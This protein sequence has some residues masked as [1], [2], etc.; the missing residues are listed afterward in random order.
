MSRVSVE[1]LVHFLCGAC[2]KWWS[3]AD[4]PLPNGY[5]CPWCGKFQP[6]SNQ[7]EIT[8]TASTSIWSPPAKN[9]SK[10]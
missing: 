3:I 2:Q 6:Y 9:E 8:V 7:F 1:H 10:P 4:A 5:Y